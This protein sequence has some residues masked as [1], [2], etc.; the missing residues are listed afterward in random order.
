M[1]V[2]C[3]VV[4]VVAGSTRAIYTLLSCNQQLARFTT[5]NSYNPIDSSILCMSIAFLYKQLTGNKHT[6]THTRLPIT[7][8]SLVAS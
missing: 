3:I 4:V 8:E 7:T 2:N 6:H 1:Q 5:R